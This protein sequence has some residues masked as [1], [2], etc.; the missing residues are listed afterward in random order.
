[1]S[2]SRIRADNQDE[3]LAAV[4]TIAPI[5]TSL[6]DAKT[7]MDKEGFECKI[8][9]NDSFSEDPGFIGD[10]DV[11]RSVENV[12]YLK[13]TRIESAGFLVC[14]LWTVAIVYDDADTV[15]DVLVLHQMDGP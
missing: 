8:I 11:Y 12:N 1:M 3:M 15:S 10:N 14:H 2:H 7:Q 9:K 4:L 13:C 5:G 6:K